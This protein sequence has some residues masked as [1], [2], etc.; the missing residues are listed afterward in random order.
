MDQT[1]ILTRHRFEIKRRLLTVREKSLIT[2]QMI[3]LVLTGEDLADLESLAPDD[4]VKLFFDLGGEKPETRDYTPRAFDREARTLTLDFAVH[5]A[6]PATRWAVGAKIGDVLTVAGPRG[7]AVLAPVFDWLLLIGDETALP[8]LGRWVEEAPAGLRVV[9]LGLVTGAAE[10][11][12]LISAA[13]HEAHWLHRADPADPAP[14]LKA[15]AELSLPEGRGFVWIAAEA[16]VARALRTHFLDERGH[17]REALKAAGYWI[18]G[19]ADA[20]EKSME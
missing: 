10:E 13:D 20:S 19:Q 11:Q 2:P 12:R 5:E 17:P 6:G 16:G 4:H 9:S 14:A 8:A 7:S 1:P 18:K 3:R 15:A